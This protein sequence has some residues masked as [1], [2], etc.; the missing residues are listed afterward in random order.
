MIYC[1]SDHRLRTNEDYR[2][3]M[4]L[5]GEHHVEGESSIA[6]LSIDLVNQTI[7]DYMHLVCLGVMEKILLAIIDGKYASSAKLSPASI[8]VLSCRLELIKKFCPKKNLRYNRL[9]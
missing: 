5:D 4:C 8:K 2:I 1:G 3:Y 6:R 9:I 7:F